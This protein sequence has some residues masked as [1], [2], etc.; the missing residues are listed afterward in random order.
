MTIKKR[1]Y[2]DNGKGNCIDNSNGNENV[3]VKG[4]ESG[5]NVIGFSNGNHNCTGNGSGNGSGPFSIYQSSNLAPRLR[6]IIQ[7]KSHRG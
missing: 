1:N 6:G 4:N 7:K 5:N 3:Y 2:T